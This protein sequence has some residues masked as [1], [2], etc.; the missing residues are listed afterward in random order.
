MKHAILLFIA[1]NSLFYGFSQQ[2]AVFDSHQIIEIREKKDSVFFDRAFDFELK[3]FVFDS[4][5]YSNNSF[6]V[7]FEIYNKTKQAFISPN[8]SFISWYDAVGFTDYNQIPL[9][10]KPDEKKTVILEIVPHHKTRMNNRGDLKGTWDGKELHLPM[11]VN[12]V[13]AAK[14]CKEE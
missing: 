13:I 4:C 14:K 9:L 10:I 3:N 2:H 11:R 5:N 12:Y 7:T 8:S 6:R 1:I